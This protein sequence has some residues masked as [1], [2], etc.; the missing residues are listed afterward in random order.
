VIGLQ[1]IVPG[2]PSSGNHMYEGYGKNRRKTSKVATYQ[3][4]VIWA[5]K[6]ALAASEWR[7]AP[8][9][10]IICEYTLY[11]GRT[12]D[13]SNVIK[14]FEDGLAEALCL[15]LNPPACCR[16][17]DARFLPRVLYRA[18]GLKAPR[19]EVQLRNFTPL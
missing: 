19:V 14:V 17:Y 15:G 1:V 7:P 11:L 5:V 13:C 2:Q 6:Q 4:E 10:D 9:G 3:S 18:I 16:A 8:S 12:M